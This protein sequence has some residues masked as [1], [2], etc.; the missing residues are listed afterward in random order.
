M[1]KGK[2]HYRPQDLLI[3]TFALVV[4]VVGLAFGWWLPLVAV[5][6]ALLVVSLV[7]TDP[8]GKLAREWVKFSSR[9]DSMQRTLSVVWSEAFKTA[10]TAIKSVADFWAP[11]EISSDNSHLNEEVYYRAT[12]ERKKWVNPFGAFYELCQ[13]VNLSC[14]QSTSDQKVED[15]IQ[16]VME[17]KSVFSDCGHEV[18][19][20]FEDMDVLT[21]HVFCVIDYLESNGDDVEL[22]RGR[23]Q[24][25][26]NPRFSTH[27]RAS[28]IG[29]SSGVFTSPN[30]TPNPTPDRTP[31]RTPERTY[32]RIDGADEY[33]I[34]PPLMLDKLDGD[35][36]PKAQQFPSF[37]F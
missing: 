37:D 7:Y 3:V 15:S 36:V 32:G 10:Q 2:L 14:P 31:D 27:V 26:L 18:I 12:P 23:M 1:A 33:T 29:S 19:K 35:H 16:W 9:H 5:L 20:N 28:S 24:G 22:L 4:L 21:K 25:C 8:L 30:R 6:V 34:G 13:A 11:T 17:H